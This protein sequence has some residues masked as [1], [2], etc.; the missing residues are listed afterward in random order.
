VPLKTKSALDVTNAFKALFAK[1]DRRPVKLQTDQ[2][3]EFYN[4]SLRQLLQE[5]GVKHFSSASEQKAA[6]AER[7][8]RTIKTKIANAIYT[9]DNERWIDRIDGYMEAYNNSVHKTIGM[10]PSDVR[11]QHVLLLWRKMYGTSFDKH[12]KST[13]IKVGDK[14]RLSRVKGVF[15]KGYFPNWTEE[16]YVV[17]SIRHGAGGKT[18]YYLVEIDGTPIKGAFNREEIQPITH[19]RYRVQVL[20][21]RRRNGVKEYFVHWVGWHNKNNSWITE[22]Q[23]AELTPHGERLH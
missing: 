12:D 1:T 3:K 20:R 6:G 5:L 18:Q 8:N 2:G 22:Q 23:F 7:F 9:H 16:H 17:D 4:S 14:V 21:T 15:E 19:N 10:A 13:G 11:P